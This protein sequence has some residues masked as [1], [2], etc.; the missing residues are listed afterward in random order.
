MERL[1]DVWGSVNTKDLTNKSNVF[2]QFENVENHNTAINSAIKAI[3]QSSV[4]Q[5][6]TCYIIKLLQ[7]LY[8]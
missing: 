5:L 3:G 6:E 4:N 1:S 8:K 7:G 2:R